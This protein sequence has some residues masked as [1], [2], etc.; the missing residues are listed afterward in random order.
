VFFSKQTRRQ[1][2]L[3]DPFPEAWEAILGD[4]VFLYRLLSEAERARLRD[5][6]RIFIAEK[7]WEG[8]R[9]QEITD[10]VKVTI[11]AQACLLV[12]G[13]N[14]YYFDDV[15]TV[16]VYPGGFLVSDLHEND[17]QNRHL[18][19]MAV[20]HGPVVL[21]WWH[22]HW[23]G[24]RASDSNLVLH[25]FAHKLGQYFDP[26]EVLPIPAD[27]A[28]AR[29]WRKVINAEYR[30]LCE[31]A[32]YD[33]PTIIDAYGAQNLAE[34]FAVATE[35]FFLQ[36]RDLKQFHPK[37]YGALAEF[38]QQDPTARRAP[39]AEERA[40][41]E[42][43]EDEYD[44]HMVA[45]ATTFLRLHPNEVAAYLN[46]AGAHEHLGEHE[47]ALADY[48]EALRLAPDDAATY[49]DRGIVYRELGRNEEALGDFNR[50]H[51][52]GPDF[53]QPLCERAHLHED[54]G[55]YAQALADFSAALAI[56][57]KD[58]LSYAGR[59][60]VLMALERYAEAQTNFDRALKLW[61]HSA[62]VL[63]LRAC[64]HWELG[65]AEKALADCDQALTLE[66]D[67]QEWQEL[68]EEILEG[69]RGGA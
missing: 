54:A 9:G 46:R 63:G 49:C 28:H 67:S 53:A 21:S 40:E 19:G 20:H 14:D 17:D 4:S 35:S 26:H 69:M 1:S 52:L 66:P 2:I 62:P 12:L 65:D 34:F 45:E 13:F 5:A 27:P 60:R 51:G 44:R 36:P 61:P 43:A 7:Y 48:S 8:C 18:L 59:G 25:E 64:A 30:R 55:D 42:A 31:D 24:R 6:L 58:D 33:R 32:D 38:Y 56:D 41:A 39:N 11:A 15:Q 22:A 10:E 57:P 37:L 16:L 47:Q 23:N 3:A 50:A 29:R 68:R